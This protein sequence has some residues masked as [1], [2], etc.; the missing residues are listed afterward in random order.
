M[1]GER[2]WAQKT[3][4]AAFDTIV[5]SIALAAITACGTVALGWLSGSYAVVADFARANTAEA[6]ACCLAAVLVGGFCGQ[7]ARLRWMRR[8]GVTAERIAE[9]KAENEELAA[10][11]KSLAKRPSRE[12]FDFLQTLLEKY[13]DKRRRIELTIDGMSP[14]CAALLSR[15]YDAGEAIDRRDPWVPRIDHAA[16]HLIARGLVVER[17][18]KLVLD[19]D[20]KEYIRDT[21]GLAERLAETAVDCLSED[22]E[23]QSLFGDID[24]ENALRE[25]ASA[26][27]EALRSEPYWQKVMLACLRDKGKVLLFHD[28]AVSTD[29]LGAFAEE[30]SE[31]M[32]RLVTLVTVGAAGTRVELSDEGS[33]VVETCPE[34]LWGTDW[35]TFAP[36]DREFA[37][38][39]ACSPFTVTCQG[40]QWMVNVDL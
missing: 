6:V 36:I 20:A 15:L 5:G 35:R 27:I 31:T 21:P 7:Y 8:Q 23:M 34:L 13:E 28:P 12:Q 29:Q 38:D 18:D 30:R 1:S 22:I 37:D 9:L 11:N 10:K 25:Q 2:N 3:I 24:A 32:G 14:A 19:A 4:D 40:V 17:D 39:P 33:Y 16:P 26:D